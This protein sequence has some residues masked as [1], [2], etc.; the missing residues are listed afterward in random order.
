MHIFIIMYV[1]TQKKNE[2]SINYHLFI[3]IYHLK[4]I[5]KMYF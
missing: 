5:R 4:S 3:I 1:N 2:K